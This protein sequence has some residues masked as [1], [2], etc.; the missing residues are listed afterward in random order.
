MRPIGSAL[1]VFW[2]FCAF[3]PDV[4][5]QE[6]SFQFDDVS[7]HFQMAR[8]LTEISGL[9]AASENSVYAHN[10]EHGIIYE[11]GLTDGAVTAAFALGDP[12]V[13]AD[14]EGVAAVD[15]RIYLVTS[16]GLV[17][18]APIGAHRGRVRYNI[19]DTGAGEFCE[20]EGIT[21]GPEPA[22]FLLICKTSHQP[23][24]E[25]G[26]LVF[27]WS[28]DERT[29]VRAPWLNL[30]LSEM[31]TSEERKK[32]RPSAI[33]WREQNES[34]FILSARNQL[35]LNVRADGTLLL[36]KTLA[37]AAHPQAEGIAIMPSG[38][39]VIADEGT[40]RLPGALTIYKSV[41]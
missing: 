34:L 21:P 14:F 35:F 33:E 19:F 28:V 18:E 25:G 2:A 1:A 15:G 38:A 7:A 27:K 16:T 24:L 4:S 12:T 29:P 20:V 6:Q 23:A 10:D 11:I 39:L 8:G 32:F 17:F 31:L 22:E 9:A 5:A 40:M 3:C 41:D 37:P 26:L 13:K 36:K 30:S